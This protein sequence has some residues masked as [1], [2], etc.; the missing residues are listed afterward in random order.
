MGSCR[1]RR[2]GDDDF[3][4][5]RLLLLRRRRRLRSSYLR[6]ASAPYASDH[7]TISATLLF[8]LTSEI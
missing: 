4:D 2:S 1:A 8:L 3:L 5:S 7:P 6:D